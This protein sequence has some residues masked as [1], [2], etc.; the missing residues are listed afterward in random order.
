MTSLARVIGG[1]LDAETAHCLVS[2]ERRKPVAIL[3]GTPVLIGD[4]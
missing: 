1:A 4:C 2:S 3:R